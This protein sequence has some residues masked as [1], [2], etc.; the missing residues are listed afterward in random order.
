MKRLF[1]QKRVQLSSLVD[2]AVV[3]PTWTYVFVEETGFPVPVLV[4][5]ARW[6]V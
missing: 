2:G 1:I 3:H 6:Y 4:G 5:Y